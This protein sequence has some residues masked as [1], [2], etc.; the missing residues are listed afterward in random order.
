MD[1]NL[2]TLERAKTYLKQL[3]NGVDPISGTELTDDTILNNV[4]ISRCFF[5][6]ADILQKVIDNGGQIKQTAKQKLLPFAITEEEKLQ[7][8]LSDEPIQIRDFCERIN[9]QIDT[10]KFSKLKVTA[11]GKWLVN[12]DFLTIEIRNNRKY[13]KATAAGEAIGI[14]S[15]WRSYGNQEYYI[16]TYS[17]EAQQF[18][19][20]NLDEIIAFSNNEK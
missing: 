9:S 12:K 15:Q 18:L 14:A 20:D 8:K 16:L 4:R 2:E 10:E 19:L 13:K 6:V 5:Y 3:A 11:F 1:K 7:V 17:K